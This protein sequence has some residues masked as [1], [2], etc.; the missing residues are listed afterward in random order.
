MPCL[1]DSDDGVKLINDLYWKY[2]DILYNK[3]NECFDYINNFWE[4]T[5]SNPDKPP[6]DWTHFNALAY[7]ENDSV[8][9][10]SSKNLSR[11]T[12]IDYSSQHRSLMH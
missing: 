2:L 8:V 10:V 11:I 1:N 7:D 9:Y 3:Y 4:E 12:K 5:Q 6:F